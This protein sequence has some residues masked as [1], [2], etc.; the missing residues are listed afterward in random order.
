MTGGR[1]AVKVRRVGMRWEVGPDRGQSLSLG[2]SDRASRMR[3]KQSAAMIGENDKVGGEVA[4]TLLQFVDCSLLCSGPGYSFIGGHPGGWVGL[5]AVDGQVPARFLTVDAVLRYEETVTY[6][7]YPLTSFGSP[8]VISP[9]LIGK[10][11][12]RTRQVTIVHCIAST[13]SCIVWVLLCIT[14]SSQGV[15]QSITLS[16][17][18]RGSEWLHFSASTPN[19]RVFIISV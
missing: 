17:V 15:R 11:G 4:S 6:E 19:G 18:F 9:D 12:C 1:P 3:V 5:W 10:Q 8:C 14:H 13:Y 2:R 7:V 16:T